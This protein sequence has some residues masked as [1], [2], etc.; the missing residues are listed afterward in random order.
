MKIELQVT[1]PN[2][3]NLLAQIGLRTKSDHYWKPFHKNIH[4]LSYELIDASKAGP[5][6]KGLLHAYTIAELG[7][8]IPWG[9]FQAAQVH[10]LPGGIW[11]ITLHTG[12]IKNYSYEVEARA[13]YLIDLITSNQVSVDEINNPVK[14]NQPIVKVKE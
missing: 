2:T 5:F 3:S 1:S 8:M 9:F 7:I 10:K 12:V 4:L 11:Q 13:N 6:L 14:P